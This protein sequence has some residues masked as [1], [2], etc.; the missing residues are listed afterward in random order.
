[1]LVRTGSYKSI[2]ATWGLQSGTLAPSQMKIKAGAERHVGQPDR[3][4]LCLANRSAVT[5]GLDG[6]RE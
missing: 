5:L 3:H 4:W 6:R 2:L 1:V